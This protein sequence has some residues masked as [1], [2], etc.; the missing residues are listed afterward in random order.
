MIAVPQQVVPLEALNFWLAVLGIVLA[1]GSLTWQIV[2][3]RLGGP[4][5][6]ARIQNMVMVSPVDGPTPV[7]EV[8]AINK[9]RAAINIT[10]WGFTLPALKDKGNEAILVMPPIGDPF[11]G[12]PLPFRLEGHSSGSWRMGVEGI[13][14]GF[15][16]SSTPLDIAIQGWV[17]LAT[18]KRVKSNGTVRLPA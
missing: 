7:V 17:T 9:G 4:R 13:R 1:L 16:Q 12:P 11:F 14:T 10:M 2:S 5:V 6:K 15:E 8:T 3:W 18:G